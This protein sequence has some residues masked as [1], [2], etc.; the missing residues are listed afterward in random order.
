MILGLL[1]AAQLNAASKNPTSKIY[2]ADVDGQAQIDIGNQVADLTKKSVYN[3]QG[4]IIE[5]KPKAF[6]AMVYSNG[7]G[8]FFDEDTRVEVKKFEQEP[9]VPNRTDM[10]VEPSVSQTKAYLA[11]GMVGI[12]TNKLVAGSSMV[13]STQSCSANIRNGKVT[14]KNEKNT[15]CISLL[16]GNLTVNVGN[17]NQGGKSLKEGEQ[18]IIT[19]N[20]PGKL[21]IVTIQ[22]IPEKELPQLLDKVT[23]AC[24]GKKTVYFDVRTKIE[25]AF[26]PPGATPRSKEIEQVIVVIPLLPTNL[27][28]QNDASPNTIH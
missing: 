18:A 4:T 12:C 21:P 22:R 5:T 6:N 10:D 17:I 7:T 1:L 20:G 9:F 3:A 16:E 15:T 24:Q 11:H 2:V 27:P 14:I 26:N 13:Y 8:I 19:E 28:L 23:L 25:N